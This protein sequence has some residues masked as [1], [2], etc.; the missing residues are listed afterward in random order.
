MDPVPYVLR[1]SRRA[2]RLRAE[3]LPGTGLV[4]VLPEG[5]SEAAIAPFL[6]RHGR[7]LRNGLR[8]AARLAEWPR[9]ALASGSTVPFLGADLALELRVGADRVE[10]S[11]PA[12]VVHVPRRTPGAVR[13]VLRAWYAREAQ[14]ELEARAR[15]TAR[16]HGLS[17]RK[18]R[19]GDARRRWG[20]CS[21]KGDLAFTWR[22]LLLPEAVAQY[23]VCHELAHLRVRGHPPA[24]YAEVE[25]LCP[26]WRDAERWLRR[27]GAAVDL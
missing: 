7:W 20:S 3:I 22:V 27:L 24:F 26:A 19:V 9:P 5:A 25:R 15:E 6:A 1:R 12:L 23:L 2:R 8:R 13:R 11:G 10:R 17:F 14:R 18:L 21:A 16:R 4:V